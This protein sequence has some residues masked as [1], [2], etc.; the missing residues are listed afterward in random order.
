MVELSIIIVT[1]NSEN[2]IKSC[3]QSLIKLITK[4]NFEIIVVDNAS[5]DNSAHLIREF[6]SQQP[7]VIFI[8]NTSNLG[9]SK[10]NNIGIKE[11][12]GKYILFLNPDVTIPRKSLDRL[13]DSLEVEK[14]R[15]IVAP[16]L[17]YSNGS[18]QESARRY[19]SL[20]VQT[21]ARLPIICKFYKNK[22]DQYLMRD[23]NH[24]ISR[25]VDW[26]IGAVMLTKKEYLCK[27]GLFDEAFFLYCEDV[28]LCYRF[29]KKGFKIYYNSDV[30]LVHDYQK[31][32]SSR[33]NKLT[34]V[35]FNSI[36]KFYRKHPELILRGCHSWQD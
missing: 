12:R 27:V 32:S 25:N 7:E 20:A 31:A 2:H 1:Y 18:V 28:D 35:H 30:E 19:P 36:I 6:K 10:A 22:L 17:R 24:Q 11:A 3:L 29:A 33:I 21:Y 5:Q 13:I 23:W 15:G 26:V 4:Y 9:Y 34:W 14:S 8:Q 16:Q